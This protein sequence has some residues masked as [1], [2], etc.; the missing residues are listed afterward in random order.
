MARL[1][2]ALQA[3]GSDLPLALCHDCNED[4]IPLVVYRGVVR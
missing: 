4:A 2:D 3:A 1:L